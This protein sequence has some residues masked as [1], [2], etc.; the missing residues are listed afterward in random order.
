MAVNSETRGVLTI[1]PRKLGWAIA[2]PDLPM[3]VRA[4]R[5]GVTRIGL[6]Y[7]MLNFE[8]KTG[9]YSNMNLYEE[10]LRMIEHY[11]KKP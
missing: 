6:R 11:R 9:K 8:R 5:I 1:T 10:V 4:V 7:Q 2:N 3:W